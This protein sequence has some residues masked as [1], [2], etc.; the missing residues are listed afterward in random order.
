LSKQIYELH[1]DYE[2]KGELPSGESFEY[3]VSN[4]R[5]FEVQ[6]GQTVTYSGVS[7]SILDSYHIERTESEINIH[8]YIKDFEPLANPIPGLYIAAQE[9]PKELI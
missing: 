2:L 5:L 9:F 7:E 4:M 6:S 8:I 3:I 1:A